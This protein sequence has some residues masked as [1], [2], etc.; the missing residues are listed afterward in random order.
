MKNLLNVPCNKCGKITTNL[1]KELFGYVFLLITI[2]YLLYFGI[3]AG[4]IIY[5]VV[6]LG[7]GLYW[8]ISRPSKKVVCEECTQ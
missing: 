6:F 8:T 3:N 4:S 5:T 1:K 7:F 2:P